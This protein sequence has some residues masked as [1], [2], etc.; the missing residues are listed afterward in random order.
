MTRICSTHEEIR[1][2]YNILIRKPEGKDNSE[3]LSIDGRII[4][5]G[6]LEK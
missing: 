6:I 5:E 1:N 4:L 3:D 2:S